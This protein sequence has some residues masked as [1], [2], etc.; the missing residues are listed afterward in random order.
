MRSFLGRKFSAVN[1]EGRRNLFR[2]ITIQKCSIPS[3]KHFS[4]LAED[5]SLQ[6]NNND[7]NE[8]TNAF[9]GIKT[10]DWSDPLRFKTLLTDE[11][12]SHMFDLFTSIF[13]S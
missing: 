10:F 12:V 7:N 11:E 13:E 6:I 9:G 3:I 5:D 4:M 1:F 8:T 2:R